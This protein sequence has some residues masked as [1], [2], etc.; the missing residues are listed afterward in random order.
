MWGHGIRG[1]SLLASDELSE[2]LAFY[3][4]KKVELLKTYEGKYALIK[5][6]ALLGVFDSASAAYEE[7]VKR[8]GNVPMLIVR[9]QK[10]EPRAWIPALQLGLIRA[11]IQG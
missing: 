8:L 2:E 1:R 7:G 10:E 9:V 11:H 3:S 4:E 5:G 6:R